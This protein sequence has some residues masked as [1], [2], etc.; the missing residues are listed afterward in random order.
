MCCLYPLV[1]WG[2]KLAHGPETAAMHVGNAVC[3]QSG[4]MG[5]GGIALVPIEAVLR[6]L[7]MQAQH[8]FIA[9][10]LGQDGGGGDGG[11][12]AVALDD[13]LAGNAGLRTI[14]AI[15]QHLLRLGMQCLHG[16]FHR[17]QGRLQDVEAVDLF[18]FGI[19]DRPGQG[20]FANEGRKSVAPFFGEF[21]GIGKAFDGTH[22]VEND[23]GRTHRPGQRAAPCFVYATNQDG[24][25]F[26][27]FLPYPSN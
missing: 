23:G 13:G 20:A 17:E 1:C 21:F 10:G 16:A 7:L 5:G 2:Q 12:P 14:Q 6:I 24:W 18:H 27:F 9:R 25:W 3:T 19:G 8:E 22:F 11:N 26:D 4:K 15:H